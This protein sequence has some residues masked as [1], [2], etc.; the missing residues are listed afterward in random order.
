MG[1]GGRGR[2]NAGV[3]STKEM[4]KGPGLVSYRQLCS[5]L[6]PEGRTPEAQGCTPPQHGGL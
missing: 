3:S 4:P 2:Q 6:F 1:Y 5:G